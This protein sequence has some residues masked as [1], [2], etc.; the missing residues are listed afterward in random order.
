MINICNRYRKIIIIDCQFNKYIFLNQRH[1]LLSIAFFVTFK[2]HR[3]NLL[4]KAKIYDH[5]II[6][7]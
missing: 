1:R 2:M 7:N 5:F 3:R 4:S 6:D